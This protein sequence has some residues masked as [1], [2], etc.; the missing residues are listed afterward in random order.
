M[1]FL[2]ITFVL[3]VDRV[4]D[5]SDTMISTPL[6]FRNREA[7]YSVPGEKSGCLLSGT[8]SLPPESPLGSCCRASFLSRKG[9]ERYVIERWDKRRTS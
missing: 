8:C 1:E 2:S 5:D 3:G 4:S 9:D 6:S 7:L